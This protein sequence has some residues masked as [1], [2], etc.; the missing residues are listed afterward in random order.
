MKIVSLFTLVCSTLWLTGCGGSGSSDDSTTYPTAY[1]QFYNGS[2]NSAT[3]AMVANLSDSTSDIAVGSAGFADATPLQSMTA[4]SYNL[5]LNYTT[6]SGSVTTVLTDKTELKN[7]QKTLLLMTGNYASP[8]LINLTFARD[9]TLDAQFKLMLVNLINDSKTYDLYLGD[10]EKTFAEAELVGSAGYKTVTQAKT[11]GVDSYILYLTL[12]GDKTVL[13]KSDPITLNYL[14]EYVMVA[15]AAVGPGQGKLAIDIIANTTTVTTLEDVNSNAQFRVYNSID[16]VNP[17]NI[18]LGELSDTPVFSGLAADTLSPFMETVAGDYRVSLS[19]QNNQ[20]IMRNGL[21]T[22]NQG[23]VKTVVFYLDAAQKAAAITLTDSKL[24]QVYDFNFNVVNVI[25]GFDQISV[26]FVKPGQTMDTSTN[27]I[28]TLNYASQSPVSL[29]V[30]EYTMY[31]V[32]KDANNNKILLAQTEL[33]TLTAG[34]NYLL[35]AEPDFYAN[36]GYKLSLV[37]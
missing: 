27:S 5:K 37:K 34:S 8:E 6:T 1:L 29:P 30:G 7:S 21:V 13:F 23:A 2:A 32:H 16:S 18:H 10:A 14:T 36:S 12:G 35:V 19:D 3:T 22:L 26:Y 31:I 20:L 17:A 33:L 15:R 25:P 9:D 11:Y 24:P 4:G 28:S